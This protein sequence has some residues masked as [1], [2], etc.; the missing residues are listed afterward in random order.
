MRSNGLEGNQDFQQINLLGDLNE[1]IWLKY[2][3]ELN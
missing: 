3:G 1:Q 2:A